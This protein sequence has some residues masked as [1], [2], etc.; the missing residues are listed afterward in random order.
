[1][2]KTASQFM[3]EISFGQSSQYVGERTDPVSKEKLN[4]WSVSMGDCFNPAVMEM[5]M[6]KTLFRKE[7]TDL[8]VM[9]YISSVIEP[10]GNSNVKEWSLK[11]AEQTKPMVFGTQ[12]TEAE[13]AEFK[14]SHPEAFARHEEI[15]NQFFVAKELANNLTKHYIVNDTELKQITEQ[16]EYPLRERGAPLTP[17]K[18]SF[19]NVQDDIPKTPHS[20]IEGQKASPEQEVNSSMSSVLARYAMKAKKALG[21]SH[22]SP[23]M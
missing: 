6:P 23:S 4:V 2:S 12:Y 5:T 17:V 9:A 18:G 22:D 11:H 10:V 15:D 21:F 20:Q 3:K 16:L 14:Q 13:K 8:E 19:Q 7:P 1:M